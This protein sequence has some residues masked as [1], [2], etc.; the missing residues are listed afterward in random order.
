MAN[1]EKTFPGLKGMLIA[2][3]VVFILVVAWITVSF[4]GAQTP[5]LNLVDVE[6]IMGL[7][8]MLALMVVFAASVYG[9]AGVLIVI[10]VVYG[11][12]L[13]ARNFRK[14]APEGEAV[15]DAL[16]DVSTTRLQVVELDKE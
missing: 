7:L 14:K 12:F 6:P 4:V 16:R 9:G 1:S 11:I 8:A 10:W 13:L 3:L 2:S 15:S 5:I